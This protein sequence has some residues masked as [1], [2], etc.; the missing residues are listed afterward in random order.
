[1]NL[2]NYKNLEIYSLAHQLTL[3]FY[4][5]SEKFPEKE[6]KNLG[7]QIIRAATS[8]PLNIAEGSGSIS[9]KVFL[10]Y[11]I[12]SY[13]SCLELEAALYLVRDLNY[14]DEKELDNIYEKLDKFVRKLYRYMKYI[15]DNKLNNKN[16]LNKYPSAYYNQQK[17]ILEQNKL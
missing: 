11:L 13:R 3:D 15:E 4:S 2:T 12:Y 7:S 17:I 16:R 6:S 10:N 1:M 8:I 5:L 14:I 9:Y